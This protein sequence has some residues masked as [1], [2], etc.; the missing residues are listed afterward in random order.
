M[1]PAVA[2]AANVRNGGAVLDT[3]GFNVSVAQ[4]LQHSGIPGDNALD[5]GL[6]K[7]G[8]GTLMITNVANDFTGNSNVDSGVLK[9][10]APNIP[11]GKRRR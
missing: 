11:Q 6:T 1:A 7:T 4:T 8:N 10:N 3:A 5:G 9:V 2:S